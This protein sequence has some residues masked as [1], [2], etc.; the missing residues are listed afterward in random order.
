MKLSTFALGVA[1]LLLAGC[2]TDR[3]YR[4]NEAQLAASLASIENDQFQQAEQHAIRVLV[5]TGNVVDDYPL[6][7][8]F[9]SYLL[10]LTH[11]TA[12]FEKP[13][14][15]EPVSGAWAG[16][17]ATGS[18]RPSPVG[19][20][21][22]TTYHGT[23]GL[24]R[25]SGAIGSKTVV[26]KQTLL[27]AALEELGAENASTHI[28]LCLLTV[29]SR[30]QYQ[31][32]ANQVLHSIPG[33]TDLAQLEPLLERTRTAASMRP[34]IYSAVFANLKRSKESEK[35]AYKFAIRTLDCPETAESAFGERERQVIKD[36]ITTESSYVFRCPECLDSAV[37]VDF[38]LCTKCRNVERIDFL[39]EPR[40][41]RSKSPVDA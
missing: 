37:N 5:D 39:G 15:T 40:V 27:P 34:W 16:L 3:I 7:R 13:Y 17:G 6:Q 1:A 29:Y 33:A 19:H 23:Y 31:D 20:L 11:L 21:V 28:K 32:Q 2:S 4:E 9:A 22:A 26:D 18:R 10:T 25:L 35:A 30:L 8:F 41:S 38:P 36:W 14:L 12:F 24:E